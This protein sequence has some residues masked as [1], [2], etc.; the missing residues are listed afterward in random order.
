MI[1]YPDGYD[2]LEFT[3]LQ[4]SDEKISVLC[5]EGED[6][7]FFLGDSNFNS[8]EEEV[9][10]TKNSIVGKY[11]NEKYDE[12]KLIGLKKI[13]LNIFLYM[14]CFPECI[15]NAPPALIKDVFLV[16]NNI[17]L[18]TSHKLQE[19]SANNKKITHLRT[20]YFKRLVSDFYTNKRGQIVFVHSSIVNGKAIT[21]L[22]KE[23]GCI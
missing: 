12:N 20:G 9:S 1:N 13:A 6:V 15:K 5:R 2:S 14:M 21:L 18:K 8:V 22:E 11:L 10:N 7:F 23:G 4:E 3:Y 19:T 17:M 16:K